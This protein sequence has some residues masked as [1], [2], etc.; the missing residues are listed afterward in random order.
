MV[1]THLTSAMTFAQ[2]FDA[3]VGFVWRVLRHHGVAERDLPDVAQ[4]TF[5][6]IHRRLPEH[7]PSRGALRTWLFGIARNIARNHQRLHRVQNEVP[8]AEPPEHEDAAPH[9]DLVIDSARARAALDRVMPR[10]DE[11]QRTVLVLH[12]M[13][14][15]PMREIAEAE[16]IPVATAYSRLRLAR[17]KLNALLAHE[18]GEKR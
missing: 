2:L 17:A 4:E 13:E 11:D 16:G 6:V 7:D 8:T 3:E 18:L 5:I 1:A 10:L 15:I 9:P 14:E 12:D